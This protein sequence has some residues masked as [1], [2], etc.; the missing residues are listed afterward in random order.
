MDS[1]IFNAVLRIECDDL[2][3]LHVPPFRVLPALT[4][5]SSPPTSRNAMSAA[6]KCSMISCRALNDPA[7]AF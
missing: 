4:L 3:R 6:S 7:R 5:A 2:E 1:L